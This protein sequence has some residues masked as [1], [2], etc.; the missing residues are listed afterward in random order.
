MKV[1]PSTALDVKRTEFSESSETKSQ[2]EQTV[3]KY[4]KDFNIT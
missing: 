3:E 4:V 2:K 1:R